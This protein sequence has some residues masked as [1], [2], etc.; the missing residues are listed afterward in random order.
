MPFKPL[1]RMWERIETARADSDAAL[2]LDLLYGGELLSKLIVAGLVAAIDDDRERSRYRQLHR[3]VRAQG[4]SDWCMAA[5]EVL[6][7]PPAQHLLAAARE[8]QKELTQKVG[9]EAWQYEAVRRL[10]ACLEALAPESL[11]AVAPDWETL[12]A[13]LDGRKWLALFVLLRNKT[14]GHGAPPS[15]ICGQVSPDLEQSLRLVC[16]HYALFRRPWAYLHRNLSCKYR[17]TRLCDTATAFDYLKTNTS[18]NLP[19][20]VYVYLGRPARVELIES[21]PDATD[22]FF[23]NGGFNQKRYELI[24]YLTGATSYV[25]AT[26]Y[27]APADDLPASESHSLGSLEIQ[28]QCFGNLPP[29]PT[30]YIHRVDLETEL[31]DRLVDDRHP[32]ITLVGRGGVG[33]TSLALAV[34][35]GLTEHD[36]FAALLWF[37]ARDIDLLPE[38]PKPVKPQVLTQ[39]DI[40][41][42]FAR[43]LVPEQA[44]R[45]DFDSTRFLAE[46][47]TRSPSGPLLFVFDNFETVKDPVELYTWVDT[48]VRPPN[49]V[50]I[51][52]RF[53]EF[54]GDYPVEV[55][56]MTEAECDHLVDLRARELE[57]DHLLTRDYRQ[58]LFRESEGHPY[59]VKVLLGE[60]AKAG[61][62]VKVERIVAGRDDILTALFE[63]TFAALSPV[64][65]RVLLTLCNWRSTVPLLALEAVLLRPPNERMDIQAA[66]EELAQ[67]SLVEIVN[68]EGSEVFLSVPLVTAMFGKRKLAVSPLKSAVEADRELLLAF[69]ASRKGDVRHGI[70]PRVETLFRNVATAVSLGRESLAE[71]LPMLEFVAH[72]YPP[73]W[74]LLATL[75]EESEAADGPERAQEAVRAFLESSPGGSGAPAAWRR[76]ADLCQRTGD[77]SGEAHALVEWCQLPLVP[78]S[79]LSNTA[80]K[81]DERLK[82]HPPDWEA[83]E[84]LVLSRR[85]AEIMQ[86]RLTEADPPDHAALARLF[87]HLGDNASARLY[88]ERGLAFDPTDPA[89]QKMQSLLGTPGEATT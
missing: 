63:R 45:K 77:W 65:R 68:G 8:E 33:K 52:T 36:R 79:V 84:I 44:S 55:T 59:V 5:D 10:H 49:K 80:R 78:F 20:G 17:V 86:S 69:G 51:T 11:R 6:L 22:F 61:R 15:A 28:G 46:S 7:G 40:A 38:G 83:E 60:V 74:L 25:E 12:P 47:L 37:S 29:L 4:L 1:D 16:D 27:L 41:K 18:T 35:H 34:I 19:D 64:A 2:F 9:P 54:K 73:A 81:L 56:G 39:R 62:A 31:R 75:H 58:E 53:R 32:I 48:Y 70:R 71:H 30:G 57:I 23:P 89:C 76:L 14:R 82:Q 24:S 88:T 42:E 67:S 50:L 66:V 26:P 72:R 85:L 3:L 43:L 21:T 87:L 13:R